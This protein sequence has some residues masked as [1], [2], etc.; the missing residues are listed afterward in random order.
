VY[1]RVTPPG[2]P[3]PAGRLNAG[4]LAQ[5]GWLPDAHPA[6]FVCGPTAFVETVADLLVSAGHDS[7]VIKTERFGPS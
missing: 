1:T 5:A 3:V 6:V 2:W 7:R 4:V